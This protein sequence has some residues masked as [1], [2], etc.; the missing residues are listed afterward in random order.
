MFNYHLF[1]R[2]GY[3][4]GFGR[5]LSQN[6]LSCKE[7]ALH[8]HWRHIEILV[9]NLFPLQE[10]LRKKLSHGVMNKYVEQL[11]EL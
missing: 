3:G 10:A 1:V 11:F 6:F 9:A 8:Y 7:L 2:I 4:H 5:T